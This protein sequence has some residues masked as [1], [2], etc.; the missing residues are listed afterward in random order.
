[1]TFKFFIRAITL[2]VAVLSLQPVVSAA[3]PETDLAGTIKLILSKNFAPDWQGIEKL[4]GI[5]WAP[6][7]PTMLQNC[8]PDGG[9][10]LRQGTLSIGGRNLAVL[11]T[12]ARSMVMHLYFRNAAAP[13]GE[14]AVVA[15]LKQGGLSVELARC[16]VP[17]TTGGTNWYRLKSAA[18][19]PGYVSIQTS[20]NGKPCEGFTVSFGEDLPPLQPNQ[21]RLYSEKC[22]ATEDRKA[23]ST[24]LPHEQLAQIFVALL[25]QASSPVS[26]DWKRLE[27][28]LSTAKW[29]P[30]YKNVPAPWTR[31]GQLNLSGRE[32]SLLAS[33]SPAQIAAISFDEN[34][35]HPRGED[36]LGSLRT[37]GFN[38]RLVRCGPV[39][40]QSINNWYSLT[41]AKTHPV[42]LRQS[43][44]LDGQ[45]IQDTYEM[46]LDNTLAK[47]D[48]R[49]R[50]PGV[51]GCR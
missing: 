8:L 20:C 50:D 36:L 12:G 6:L 22:S 44:R 1:M 11:A 24:V 21:Q 33:G 4:P 28:S 13:I 25:P 18:T 39:Y 46:R 49:D 34:G 51:N 5:K 38:V 7:P 47:R 2:A 19:E 32:F 41:S 43:L 30:P 16:P 45:Q 26:Y 23:V 27:G 40:T 14:G 42:L 48:P 29:S 35:L 10:F 17:N 37:Q 15:S 3:S 31:S 9:C